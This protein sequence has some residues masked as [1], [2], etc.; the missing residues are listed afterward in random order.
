MPAGNK[1]KRYAIMATYA[2]VYLE[3]QP[4][5]FTWEVAKERVKF[6]HKGFRWFGV[7]KKSGRNMD[8]FARCQTTFIAKGKLLKLSRIM[9]KHLLKKAIW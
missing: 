2:D 4:N 8:D 1:T 3:E 7:V 5:A 6:L 9:S